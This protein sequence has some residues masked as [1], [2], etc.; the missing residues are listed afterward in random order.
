[1]RPSASPPSDPAVGPRIGLTLGLVLGASACVHP[2]RGDWPSDRDQLLATMQEALRAGDVLTTE[3]LLARARQRYP[4]DTEVLRLD[5]LMAD[6]RWRD[7]IA[8]A[9]LK[10]VCRLERDPAAIAEA[11]G[12]AGEKLFMVGY[13]RESEA[14]LRAALGGMPRRRSAC[15]D[16]R[17]RIWPGHCRRSGVGRRASR[18]VPRWPASRCRNCCSV[19]AS[20]AA[21]SCSIRVPRSRRCRCRSRGRWAWR[22]CCRAGR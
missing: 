20:A 4:I 7:E 22:R 16:R 19:L 1:M 15:G 2:G 8:I 5:A 14:H 18:R 12:R 6:M 17:G 11:S 3:G 9:D 13:W 10:A 21:P